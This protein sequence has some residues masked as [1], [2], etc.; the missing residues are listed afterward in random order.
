MKRFALSILVLALL[1]VLALPAAAEL[2]VGSLAASRIGNAWTLDGTNMEAARAK[3]ENPDN[4]GSVGGVDPVD[5]DVTDVSAPLTAGVLAPFDVFF[6]GYTPDGTLADAELA[7]LQDWV[8]AGGSLI[9]TCDDE[10]HDEICEL[11]GRTLGGNATPPTEPAPGQL[12]HPLFTGPFGTATTIVNS[13]NYSYFASAVGATVLAVDDAGL[14]IIL[15]EGVGDGLVLS[16]GDVDML[17]DFTLSS[18]AAIDATNDNDV[19]LGNLFAALSGAACP[20][21]AL[22]LGAGGRFEVTVTWE[23][24]SG[25]SGVGHPVPLTDDSGSFWFFNPNNLEMI[26]K[27]LD[28]CPVNNRFWVF[29]GGL[30]NVEV[31]L[32]VVDTEAGV[33]KVY[34]NPVTTPFQ[35]IQDTNAFATCP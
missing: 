24:P 9:L 1:T 7:A 5:I 20:P 2:E 13:G 23:T 34:T 3:L 6:I 4:F 10:S 33:T 12:T 18:G 22:C 29:A 8:D 31:V 11:F 16:M 32:T 25:D 15:I 28:G 30:T 21:G 35:P 14:P 17:S 27:V 26:V 19:L